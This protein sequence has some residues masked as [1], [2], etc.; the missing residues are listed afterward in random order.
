MRS[1]RRKITENSGPLADLAFMLLF[2]FM[3]TTT[4]EQDKGIPTELPK[5]GVTV[6]TT[7]HVINI[8]LNAE[9]GIMI[10]EHVVNKLECRTIVLDQLRL[11]Q[12]LSIQ[13]K[14]N[15]SASYDAYIQLYDAVRS[16][17][18]EL[19]NEESKRLFAL[20]YASLN[21]GQKKSIS[22]KLPIRIMEPEYLQF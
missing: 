2:F 17:Y 15:Q 8:I 10:D 4:M 20:D 12:G 6:G 11:N 5:M 14:T 18:M 16:A 1:T 9:N 13:L 22:E 3:V 21:P 19:Y 7:P